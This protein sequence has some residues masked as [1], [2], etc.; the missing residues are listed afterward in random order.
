[1]VCSRSVT[2][3]ALGAN[4]GQGVSVNRHRVAAAA[5]ALRAR[6]GPALRFSRAWRTPAF[7]PGAGGDFVN[8]CALLPR[9][10]DPARALADLHAIEARAGRKRHLRWTARILDL[11]L[12]AVGGLIRPDIPTLRAWIDL[13]V[14]RQM[15]E[16]PG[17]LL[18]PHPRLQD[19]A[20]VLG[21]LMDL[22]PDWRHPLT[23]RSVAAMWARIPARDRTRL[24]PLGRPL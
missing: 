22:A 17:N 12:L 8:A 14:A 9:P 3:I 15:H 20:F 23:G 7:P 10:V 1:M 2:L 21:P 24:R 4:A 13:P 18:L 16:T 11:D 6:L 19:R 5:A